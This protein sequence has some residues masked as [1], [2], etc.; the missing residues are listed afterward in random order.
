MDNKEMGQE[1]WSQPNTLVDLLHH[2]AL[3]Q[4]DQVAYTFLVD[5]ENNGKQRATI[6]NWNS[7]VLRP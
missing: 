7:H 3:C 2:R 6:S 4:P 5:G 1:P